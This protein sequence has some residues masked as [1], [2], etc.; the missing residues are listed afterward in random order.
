[1][2]SAPGIISEI[3]TTSRPL[4]KTNGTYMQLKVTLRISAKSR[5]WQ[6]H[7]HQNEKGQLHN[8]KTQHRKLKIILT[9]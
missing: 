2:I 4:Y 7:D 5:D 1:M 9:L 6:D 3:I 8:D